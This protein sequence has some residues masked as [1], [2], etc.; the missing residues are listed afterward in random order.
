VSAFADPENI[1]L[2]SEKFVPVTA[3]DWYQRRR[4]DAEGEFFRKVADQGPRNGEGGS[5]RQGIYCFTADGQL[6]AYKNAGQNAEVMREVFQQALTAWNRLP[7]ERRMPGAVTVGD[8]GPE[9]RNYVRTPPP[10]GAIVT[11]FTRILDHDAKGEVCRGS[12]ATLGGDRAARDHLWLMAEEVRKLVPARPAVG[13]QYP[14]PTA[15]AERIVRFHLVDNTRGEPPFWTHEQVRRRDL[16]LTVE[17]VTPERVA[18]TLAGSVLLSDAADPAVSARGFDAALHGAIEFDRAKQTLTRFDV[19]ALGDHW[20]EATFTRGAR[21][22]RSRLGVA[23]DLSKGD[24][25]GDRVP[26]QAA[27]EIGAYLGRGR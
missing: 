6:L 11:V 10:G 8:P 26:P 18:L 4:Q 16:T 25:P 2:A 23:F 1:R 22:G 5:T 3:D 13:V 20:G 21:P 15:V 12:C 24:K 19:V 27:R 14:L 7:A 9:D 17:S